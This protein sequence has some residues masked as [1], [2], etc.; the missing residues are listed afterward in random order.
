MGPV[1]P[2][3]MDSLSLYGTGSK[4]S[5]PILVVWRAV[6][7]AWSADSL[8]GDNPLIECTLQATYQNQSL[9]YSMT[10]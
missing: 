6:D 10:H 8:Y 2:F 9:H 3:L 5:L 7:W 4:L 1:S